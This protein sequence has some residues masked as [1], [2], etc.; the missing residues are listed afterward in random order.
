MSCTSGRCLSMVNHSRHSFAV[1]VL[2]IVNGNGDTLSTSGRTVRSGRPMNAE[3]SLLPDLGVYF[4]VCFQTHFQMWRSISRHKCR[5]IYIL[6]TFQLTYFENGG[7]RH[8]WLIQRLVGK[9]DRNCIRL[10][11]RIVRYRTNE[12][13]TLLYKPQRFKSEEKERKDDRRNQK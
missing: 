9:D 4:I 2:R 1:A 6:N 13:D 8:T 7:Q 10:N 11:Q 12:S 5:L 3:L